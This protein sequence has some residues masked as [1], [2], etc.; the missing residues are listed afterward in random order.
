MIPCDCASNPLAAAHMAQAIQGPRVASTAYARV[1]FGELRASRA[2]DST[3]QSNL[4]HIR[5]LLARARP[6]RHPDAEAPFNLPACLPLT[7]QRGASSPLAE[8][9]NQPLRGVMREI[10]SIRCAGVPWRGETR[11]PCARPRTHPPPSRRG[12]GHRG[13][14]GPPHTDS[15]GADR[16]VTVTLA[17]SAAITLH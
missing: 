11:V 5:L 4:T 8:A 16:G 9:G 15:A 2:C 3:A 1:A 7:A 12:P 13:L 17:G 6:Y 14:L 10:R